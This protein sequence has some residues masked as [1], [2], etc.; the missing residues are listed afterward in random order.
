MLPRT[1]DVRRCWT[2]VVPE[3]DQPWALP[4][5]IDV[6]GA[7]F[8]GSIM[9]EPAEGEGRGPRAGKARRNAFSARELAAARGIGFPLIF[10]VGRTTA[11]FARRS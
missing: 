9:G 2:A 1:A 10:A 6:H 8:G 11:F 5:S 3:A 7:N 4:Q